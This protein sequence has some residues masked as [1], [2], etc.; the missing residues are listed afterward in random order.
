MPLGEDPSRITGDRRREPQRHPE[1][2][3]A[4]VSFGV[5]S[6]HVGGDLR[7]RLDFLL[8]HANRGRSTELLDRQLMVPDNEVACPCPGLLYTMS[9]GKTFQIG[10]IEYIGLLRHKDVSICALSAMAFYVYFSGGGREP[11]SR[12][13]ASKANPDWCGTKWQ[14]S[15]DTYGKKT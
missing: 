7:G 3:L 11:A 13:L 5:F 6:L 10:K 15:S 9:N 12:F 4:P 1:R 8:S 14:S 2:I